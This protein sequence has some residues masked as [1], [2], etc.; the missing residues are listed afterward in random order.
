MSI[1]LKARHAGGQPIGD[2][3]A[4]ALGDPTLISL[5]AGFVDD[6]TLPVEIAR[7]AAAKLLA[8][9]GLA[10]RA[11]QYGTAAGWAPLRQLLWERALAADGLPERRSQSFENVVCT[12]G[13]NQILALASEAVL[14]PGDIVLCASPTYFVYLGTLKAIGAVAWGVETDE[15]GIVPEALEEAFLHFRRHGDFGRVRMIYDVSYFDNPRGISQSAERRGRLVEIVRKWSEEEKIYLLED[16]A[17]RELRYD[18]DDVPTIWSHDEAGEHVI[19]AGTFSKSF[20]PG[21]RVGYG[22]LPADLVLP[23]LDLKGNL[24]FGSPHLNQLLM[25]EVL[26]SGR[27]DTHVAALRDAYRV[28]RDAML[29]TADEHFAGVPGVSWIAPE[30]GLYVWLTLPPEL[31]TVMDGDLF[32]ACVERGVLYVPGDLCFPEA[33]VPTGE[34]SMRLSFGVCS[35]ARIAEGM[36]KLADAVIDTAATAPPTA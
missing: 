6:V 21:V 33:G 9:E 23:T 5:A 7:E 16:A 24:D 22:I 14:D 4:R 10:R 20:S 18:G 25:Y 34:S 36:K 1:S 15:Y 27:Y 12:A 13:S 28:K 2:L 3:M 8:D 35:E 30:G 32:Q 31:P 26:T 19:L 29:R 17:Y 11:L